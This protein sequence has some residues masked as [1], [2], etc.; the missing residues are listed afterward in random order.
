MISLIYTTATFVF[1]LF[2]ITRLATWRVNLSDQQQVVALIAIVTALGYIAFHTLLWEVEPRY[3]QAI[4]PLL[5]FA[6]AALPDRSNRQFL[7][8]R[9]VTLKRFSAVLIAVILFVTV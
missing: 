5:M 7:N 4:L 6:L 8:L 3:G 9:W 1:W 2:L